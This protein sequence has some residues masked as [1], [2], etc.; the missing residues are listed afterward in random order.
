V[1]EATELQRDHQQL[2][3]QYGPVHRERL[4]LQEERRLLK[5]LGSVGLPTGPAG[6]ADP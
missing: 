1:Q 3:D 4:Q 2:T 6:A 5:V